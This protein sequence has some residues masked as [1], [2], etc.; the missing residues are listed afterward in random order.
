MCMCVCVIFPSKI[1]VVINTDRSA[2][3]CWGLDV[4]LPHARQLLYPDLHP[5]DFL[6]LLWDRVSLSCQADLELMIILPQF[7]VSVKARREDQ[8]SWKQSYSWLHWQRKPNSRQEQSM[9]LTTEP[10]LQPSL[11][12]HISFWL[13]LH[14]FPSS[15]IL[16]PPPHPSFHFIGIK[17]SLCYLFNGCFLFPDVIVVGL[18]SLLVHSVSGQLGGNSR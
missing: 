16:T 15:L 5:E 14:L 13:T 8:I 9:P 12:H 17:R 1:Q 4:G 7:P 2:F 18:G 3:Q 10:C 11:R 6:Y